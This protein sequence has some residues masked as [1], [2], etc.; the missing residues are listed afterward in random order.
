MTTSGNWRD[1]MAGGNG[2][3]AT[4][5]A[6]RALERGYRRLLRW[7][8]HSHRAVY[9][10]EMLGVLIAGTRP[11]Q[12][13]PGRKEGVREPAGWRGDH[14]APPCRR[15]ADQPIMAGRVC[16]AQR[17]RS[18]TDADARGPEPRS[19]ANDVVYLARV[20]PAQL[21]REMAPGG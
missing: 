4:G 20:E 17:R 11:G 10:E 2:D 19:A 1:K 7:Y 8:P 15:V 12:R 14:P 18:G 9:G 21:G 13:R 3:A 5:G 6:D 16:R